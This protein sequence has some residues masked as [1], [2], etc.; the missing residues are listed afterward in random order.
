[1]FTKNEKKKKRKK[2]MSLRSQIAFLLLLSMIVTTF[3]SFNIIKVYAATATDVDGVKWN[4][5]LDNGCATNVY[6]T[7]NIS[8]EVVIPDLI[9]NYPVVS[10]GGGTKETTV[11][12]NG[13]TSISVPLTVTRINDYAF[14]KIVS[15]KDFQYKDTIKNGVQ[16]TGNLNYVGNYAF[17]GCSGIR[18]VI[19]SSD[20]GSVSNYAFSEC[21]SLEELNL[22]SFHGSIGSY[23]FSDCT[24]LKE[25]YLGNITN[26]GDYVFKG[27]K[28]LVGVEIN[29]PNLTNQFQDCYNLETIVF[30]DKVTSVGQDAFSVSS[31]NNGIV[32]KASTENTIL[33]SVNDLASAVKNENSSVY[34]GISGNNQRKWYFKNPNT[35][36]FFGK[37]KIALASNSTVRESFYWYLWEQSI[38]DPARR[39]ISQYYG[40]TPLKIYNQTKNSCLF[41]S[42]LSQYGVTEEVVLAL[43]NNLTVNGLSES[44]IITIYAGAMMSAQDGYT[45]TVGG[46][47]YTSAIN[48]SFTNGIYYNTSNGY[49]SNNIYVDT[50]SNLDSSLKTT[51]DTFSCYPEYVPTALAGTMYATSASNLTKVFDI[52]SVEIPSYCPSSYKTGIKVIYDGTVPETSV[53]D[54]SRINVTVNYNLPTQKDYL[55]GTNQGVFFIRTD[56]AIKGNYING[57]WSENKESYKYAEYQK[58]MDVLEENQGIK[59]IDGMNNIKVDSLPDGEFTTKTNITAYYFTGEFVHVGK[60]GTYDYDSSNALTPCAYLNQEEGSY[61]KDGNYIGLGGSYDYNQSTGQ[62]TYNILG[63]YAPI[64]YKATTDILVVENGSKQSMTATFNESYFDN[65]TVDEKGCVSDLDG[66]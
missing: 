48:S 35:K 57:K 60:G 25:L 14:N 64:I 15:L 16:I 58:Y 30:G 42:V 54:P 49:A 38:G 23:A 3:G 7:D 31:I 20:G 53:V 12:K 65:L 52:D 24:S 61:D 13:V 27:N 50:G 37:P 6:T 9:N 28:S 17:S 44:T 8:G 47:I 43:R 32:T 56:K 19:L 11:V 34:N 2:L 40:A 51:S 66:N 1:M 63:E 36:L 33:G 29:Y 26:L 59:T 46:K 62:I 55:N 45:R 39:T 21:V 10:I 4:Y 18:N 22:Y 41:P 5:T